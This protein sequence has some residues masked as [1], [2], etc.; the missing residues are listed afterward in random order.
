MFNVHIWGLYVQ[1]R[2]FVGEIWSRVQ[3]GVWSGVFYLQNLW[4]VLL[5]ILLTILLTVH[6]IRQIFMVY[7]DIAILP[8]KS[9]DCTLDCILPTKSLDCT[10]DRT[11]DHTFHPSNIDSVSKSVDCTHYCSHYHTH[12]S[13]NHCIVANY[14]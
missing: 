7:Q 4:T 6:S 3:S 12:D 11:P 1:S 8:T 13:T 2:D 10:L 9:P 14:I 5:T